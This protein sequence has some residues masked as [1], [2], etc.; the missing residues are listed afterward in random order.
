M[1]LLFLIKKFLHYDAAGTDRITPNNSSSH[2]LKI[3]ACE[4]ALKCISV[5]DGECVFEIMRNGM[6][7]Q[8]QKG[9]VNSSVIFSDLMPNTLYFY[10][11][12]FISQQHNEMGNFTTDT[13]MSLPFWQFQVI[14]FN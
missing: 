4:A 7:E 13:G 12:N 6:I 9:A 1:L 11:I 3:F 10:H 14:F 5:V 2:T 8:T